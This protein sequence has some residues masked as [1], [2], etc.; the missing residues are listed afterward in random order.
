MI[1]EVLYGI[2]EDALLIKLRM[3]I[4]ITNLKKNICLWRGVGGKY[5]GICEQHIL[6]SP[7]MAR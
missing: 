3:Q 7:L 1:A 2:S 4:R 6:K 5:Q